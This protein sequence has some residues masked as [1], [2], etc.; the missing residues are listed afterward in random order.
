QVP[1][2]LDGGGKPPGLDMTEAECDELVAYIRALPAPVALDPYGPQGTRDIR[3]GRRLFADAGCADCHIPTLGDVRGIYSDLLLHEMDPS[4]GDSGGSYG[5]QGIP[6]PEGPR[7]GEGRTP[8]FW[9]Y[10]DSRPYLHH[11]RAHDVEEAAVLHGGRRRTSAR[12]F[13][14]LSARERSE[15]EA[16]LKSLVAPS[17]SAAPGVVLAGEMESRFER[18]EQSTPESLVR[19]RREQ[20]LARDEW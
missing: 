19:R 4:S 1:S 17:A 7:P 14:A 12:R 6:V 8:P 2:P 11:R 3:E 15:V 20:A 9:G 10:R 13:F 18:E 16:F 5:S